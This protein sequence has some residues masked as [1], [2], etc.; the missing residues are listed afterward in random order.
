VSDL[1]SVP[2]SAGA[3]IDTYC[4]VDGNGNPLPSYFGH[5]KTTTFCLTFLPIY[6]AVSNAP[7]A[8]GALAALTDH[9]SQ[10]TQLASELDQLPKSIEAKATTTVDK[11]QTVITTKNP[12]LLQGN[13]GDS[14]MY[15]A[16]Y[17]GQNQ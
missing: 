17:C 12:A 13:G 15:V 3:D 6:Q 2:S 14:A 1:S 4:G 11:A 7:N 5:G 16:L 10:I 8:A 9:Q